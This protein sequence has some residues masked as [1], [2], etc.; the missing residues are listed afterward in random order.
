MK[1]LISLL[2]LSL[3]VLCI[4]AHAGDAASAPTNQLGSCAKGAAGKQGAEL[5]AYMQ[6]CVVAKATT[7]E[8][9]AK[10][11]QARRTACLAQAQG[12]TGREH[13]QFMAGCMKGD[14]TAAAPAESASAV[15][16]A[17]SN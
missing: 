10:D 12:K 1:T 4:P 17:A 11:A 9:R 14:A 3:S 7:V 13:V 2:T 16:A 15:A 6:T 5:K 8:A